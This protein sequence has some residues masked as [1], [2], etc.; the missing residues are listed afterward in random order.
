MVWAGEN[1]H[2]CLS[3]KK[4]EEEKEEEEKGLKLKNN[5]E[6]RQIYRKKKKTG[7]IHFGEK[8]KCERRKEE[9]K[10]TER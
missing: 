8:N 9:I 4:E 1:V 6:E 10:A 5:E 2:I 3:G 7:A